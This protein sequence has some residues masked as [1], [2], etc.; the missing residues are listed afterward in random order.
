V[1][2]QHELYHYTRVS[3]DTLLSSSSVSFDP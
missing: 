2:N 3:L 1:D